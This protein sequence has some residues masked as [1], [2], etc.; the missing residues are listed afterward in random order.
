MQV[1]TASRSRNDHAQVRSG[2]QS[3][4][5]IR[6]AASAIC[7]H[8]GS[9]EPLP[10]EPHCERPS[11]AVHEHQLQI[12]TGQVVTEARWTP[13]RRRKH[14]RSLSWFP[15]R[16]GLAQR[17]R[18]PSPRPLFLGPLLLEQLEAMETWQHCGFADAAICGA[19]EKDWVVTTKL[20]SLVA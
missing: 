10:H 12:A 14:S 5:Q 16:L 9:F 7:L 1:S 20:Y 19:I 18:S 3:R 8:R 4:L 2:F 11:Q 17:L 13:S 6:W 15:V